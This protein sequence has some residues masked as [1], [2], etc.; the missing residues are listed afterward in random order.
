MAWNNEKWMEDVFPGK[1]NIYSQYRNLN[2]REF[3][4]V[5]CTVVDAAISELISLRLKGTSSRELETFLG[6]NGD[7][8]APCGSL[9]AKLQLGYLLGLLTK[10]DLK[11]LRGF[12]KIRNTFAHS[13]N[14][15]FSKPEIVK[16]VKGVHKLWIERSVAIS[17]KTDFPV[18]IKRLK[19]FDEYFDIEPE[20]CHGFLLGIFTTYQA[21]FHRL[22]DR[23]I[24][25]NNA[26]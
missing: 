18:N 12:K 7:G 24:K 1:E 8:R 22:H 11:I 14:V 6:V 25:I 20:A 17:E 15:D 4:I 19:S 3:S 21:Y 2:A 26:V 23:I 13:I 5:S 16:V 10:N 9:G